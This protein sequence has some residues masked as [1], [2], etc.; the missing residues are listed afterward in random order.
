MP[1]IEEDKMFLSKDDFLHMLDDYGLEIIKI[2]PLTLKNFSQKIL[3]RIPSVK[4]KKYFVLLHKYFLSKNIKQ[5]LFILKRKL[6][7][8]EKIS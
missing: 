2:Y 6:K 1:L 5:Q 7:P 3:K 8:N 4:A